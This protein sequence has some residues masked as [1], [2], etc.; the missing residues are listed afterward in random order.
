LIFLAATGV[1]AAG[2]VVVA[3]AGAVV[4]GAAGAVVAAGAVGA[5]EVAGVVDELHPLIINELIIRRAIRITRYF[6]MR[7]P[8]IIQKILNLNAQT[9]LHHAG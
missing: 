3:C 5:A 8:P 7:P 6:F 9:G 4:I 1:V 2:A